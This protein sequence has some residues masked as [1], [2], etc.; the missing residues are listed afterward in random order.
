MF[1]HAKKRFDPAL[2]G[3]FIK[4]MG[5]YPA[6][7]TVQLTDDR[8]AVVV[9]VDSARPLK[10]RVLVHDAKVARDAALIVDLG[11]QPGLGIRRGVKPEQLPLPTL[12]YLAPR[13]RVVYYF[14]PAYPADSAR[15]A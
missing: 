12:H 6:G 1:T 2:L 4:M 5:V 13:Q 11:D 14:E 3:T 8:F 10:P 9:S 7:S 15:A